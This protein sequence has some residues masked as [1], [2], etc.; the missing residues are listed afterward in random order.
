M[1]QYRERQR[2]HAQGARPVRQRAPGQSARTR[3]STGPSSART[4]R[5][6]TPWAAAASNC[7][8]RSGR[9]TS[10]S[11]PPQGTDRIARARL[12]L[13]AQERQKPRLHRHQGQHHEDD[14]RQV[15]AHLPGGRRRSIP[16]IDDRRLVH[17]HHDRQA[18]RPKAPHATSRCSSCPTSTATSSPTR[19]REFQGGVGTAGSANLGKR[20][21]MF[22]AIH[23]SAPRMV[24]EGRGSYADPC[25][26]AARA[27][28]CCSPTSAIRSRPTS[29][30]PH[31]DPL[32]VHREKIRLSPAGTPGCTCREFG[33]D[34]METIETM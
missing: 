1:A 20:Y 8:R 2:R 17:R 21:A 32:H 13:R 30:N 33:D 12:R 24:T 28:S 14:R 22:E 15:P 18:G 11:P 23:G 9:W 5:A 27:V 7:R 26:H 10:P 16:E 29:W 31:L 4:P 6:P 3:A 19:P 25:S 34:V